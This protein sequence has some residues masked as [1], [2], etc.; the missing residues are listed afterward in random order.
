[1]MT[2]SKLDHRVAAELVVKNH[3]LH[4]KPPISFSY[5]LWEDGGLLG[6]VTFGTPA[7]HYLQKG[8]CPDDP[9]QV[10]ELN[11]LWVDDG[12]PRNTESWFVSRALRLLPPKIVV[13]YA[14]TER[15]HLGY[16]YRAL[17]FNYAGWTDMDRKTPRFDYI[18]TDPTRHPREASRTGYTEKRRRKPK[19]KYWTTTGNARERRDLAQRCA[20]PSFDWHEL[21]P[22][23]GDN[24]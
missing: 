11:R 1:M 7:S 17:N 10:I 24:R 3:Y 19:I 13:S 15:G 4:R 16:V 21:V 20:W 22:P 23:T 14:D 5:G 9:G 6:V 12:C 8:V 2:V 18:P